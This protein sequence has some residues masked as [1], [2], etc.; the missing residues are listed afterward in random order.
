MIC[1]MGND[2]M[3]YVSW[4]MRILTGGDMIHGW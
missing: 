1:L 2:D 3:S 4:V